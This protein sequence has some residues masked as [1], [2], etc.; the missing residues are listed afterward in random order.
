LH[1]DAHL[2]S[3]QLQLPLA[4]HPPL[5]AHLPFAQQPPLE[6]AHEVLVHQVSTAKANPPPKNIEAII[7]STKI[8]FFMLNSFLVKEILFFD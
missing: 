7:G 4:Q 3:A 2:P 5:Q 8:Y 1:F 6:Q